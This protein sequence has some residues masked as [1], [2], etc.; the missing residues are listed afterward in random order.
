M[1]KLIPNLFII[2]AA[3]CGTTSLHEYLDQH[4]DIFMARVKEPHYFSQVERILYDYKEKFSPEKEYHTWVIKEK[5]QYLNLFKDGEKS[6]YRGESSPSY[7]WDADAARKIYAFNPRAKLIVLLR[8]P[9]KR[10]FSHYQMGVHAGFQEM[11]PFYDALK[12]GLNPKKVG[13]RAICTWSLDFIISNWKGIR[14]YFQGN[15]SKLSALKILFLML[16]MA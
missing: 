8:N 5:D 16:K 9:I 7:L 3:K 14:N 10:A 1:E 12:E 15:K 2:G 4:P 13:T 6:I 11:K